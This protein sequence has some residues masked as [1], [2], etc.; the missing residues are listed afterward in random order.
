MQ[1][2][3]NILKGLKARFEEHHE[4]KYTEG[5]LR[6]AAS[7][8]SKHINDR[9]LPDKAIDL[10]DEAASKIRLEMNSKPEELD[11]LD[12]KL[13]Q[14]EIE[15]EAVKRENDK[16]RL[17]KHNFEPMKNFKIFYCKVN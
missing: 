8:A 10:I 11:S 1:K 2:T 16:E 15:Q 12:R 13:A 3:F 17:K 14:L 4:I 6:A 9:F 7:L 5:S